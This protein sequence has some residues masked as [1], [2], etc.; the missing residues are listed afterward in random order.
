MAT[1]LVDMGRALLLVLCGGVTWPGVAGQIA[2]QAV[3][4]APCQ[5]GAAW[6]RRDGLAD[7]LIVR[8]TKPRGNLV[9][10]LCPPP[11]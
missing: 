3:A 4:V 1:S 5:R 6:R 2:I 8:S 7:D 10:G 9:G 11:Q